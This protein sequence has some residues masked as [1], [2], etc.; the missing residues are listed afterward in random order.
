MD[1]CNGSSLVGAER[2]VK[3]LAE[4]I[5]HHQERMNNLAEI[6]DKYHVDSIGG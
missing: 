6:L 2:R 1:C 5:E 3:L 4:H